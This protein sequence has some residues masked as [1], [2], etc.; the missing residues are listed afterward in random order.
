MNITGVIVSD[1]T[2][3]LDLG[4]DALGDAIKVALRGAT[5]IRITGM[6]VQREELTDVEDAV[7]EVRY[8]NADMV[9]IE[10]MAQGGKGD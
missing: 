7:N 2:A 3:L 5:A 6:A 4:F 10:F 1:D 9:V 8:L